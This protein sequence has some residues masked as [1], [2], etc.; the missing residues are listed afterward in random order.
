MY[1]SLLFFLALWEKVL[2]GIGSAIFIILVAFGI[3]WFCKKRRKCKETKQVQTELSEKDKKGNSDYIGYC[4]NTMPS[5]QR[6]FGK[7]KIVYDGRLV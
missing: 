2:I 1:C 5:N 6:W 3:Y 7:P 4:D